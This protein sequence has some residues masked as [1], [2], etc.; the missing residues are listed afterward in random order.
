MTEATT[1]EDRN[2]KGSHLQTPARP[3]PLRQL[4]REPTPRSSELVEL[5]LIDL[6]SPTDRSISP[7]APTT[8]PLH[9]TEG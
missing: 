2:S 3:N 7:S 6:I 1:T 5:S 9:C 4:E 8:L